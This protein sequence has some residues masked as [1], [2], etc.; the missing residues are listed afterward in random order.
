MFQ[1]FIGVNDKKK[2]PFFLKGMCFCDMKKE[3]KI[4]PFRNLIII[5]T[6]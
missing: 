3:K 5:S 6:K 4:N 1:N 2:N